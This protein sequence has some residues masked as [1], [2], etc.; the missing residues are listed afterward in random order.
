MSLNPLESPQSEAEY[1]RMLFLDTAMEIYELVIALDLENMTCTTLTT[2]E[3][4]FV[5]RRGPEPWEEQ[6][7]RMLEALHPEDRQAIEDRLQ[8]HMAQAR[9]DSR[10]SVAF[11]S[12]L[13]QPAGEYGW[14]TLTARML[15]RGGHRIC[16][17]LFND[18]TAEMQERQKL[19]ALGERDGLTSLF[20]R[21]KLAEML[22]G[23]YKELESSGVIF[24]DLNG[25]KEA[26]DNFGHDVGDQMIVMVAKSLQNMERPGVT[27]YRYGGDEFLLIAEDLDRDELTRLVQRWLQG[28]RDQLAHSELSCSIAVGIAWED[29]KPDVQALIE[30]A[31]ADM[32]HN[33]NLMKAGILPELSSYDSNAAVVGLYGRQDFFKVVRLLLDGNGNRSFYMLSLSLSHFPLINVW[34][35]RETGDRILARVGEHIRSFARDQDG[36]GC[37]L[38]NGR[39][40]MLLPAD[41]ALVRR[42][43]REL[44]GI[45]RQFSSCVGFR[46]TIGVYPITDRSLK[47]FTMLDYAAEA[48]GRVEDNAFERVAF[49]DPKKL[50]VATLQQ[51]LLGDMKAGLES[52]ELD[53]WLQPICSPADGRVLSAEVLARW[54]HPSWGLLEPGRFI[55]A[56]EAG[57]LT[58]E[59][60]PVLWRRTAAQLR[61]WADEGLEPIPIAVN[62]SRSDILSLDVGDCFAGLAEEFEL[63]HRLL[64]AVISA[65]AMRGG[66]ETEQ[67]ILALRQAGFSVVLDISLS[68]RASL[69]GIPLPSDRLKVD[70]QAMPEWAAGDREL[71]GQLLARASELGKPMTVAGVETDSQVELLWDLKPDGV[72][73]FRYYRPMPIGDFAQLL[74]MRTR[75]L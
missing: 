23:R 35:G 32:Y 72:Q 20:N 51:T 45:L 47:V 55:P 52:G 58:A 61:R 26:N 5:H 67:T 1:Y 75:T 22:G 71:L 14:W 38:E 40:A 15:I 57:G 9:T 37:F 48:Q 27:P 44:G 49:H 3:E 53:F 36:L 68:P 28:W 66:R 73:G 63:E 62:V 33:K 65:E 29:G 41:R 6:H 16:M 46:P 42:L 74:S 60:D 19:R 18:V 64:R 17:L 39:F 56:L 2:S 25:L 13:M 11:R 59:L 8:E 30:R 10:F 69:G 54:N 50:S 12:T 21:T 7:R 31:D 4:G 34:F 70:L 24:L 43:D